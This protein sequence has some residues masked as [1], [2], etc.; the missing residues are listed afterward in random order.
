MAKSRRIESE[1]LQIKQKM[2]AAKRNGK[3]VNYHFLE[4]KLKSLEESA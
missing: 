2:A 4:K 3:T 1:I